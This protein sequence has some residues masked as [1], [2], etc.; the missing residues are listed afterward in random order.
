M[1]RSRCKSVRDH[2]RGGSEGAERAEQSSRRRVWGQRPGQ[3]GEFNLSTLWGFLIMYEDKTLVCKDCGAEFVFT[4]GE[5]EFYAEKGFQNE[6]TRCPAALP[7]VRAR[8]MMPSVLNAESPLRF[9]SSPERIGPFTAASAL[10]PAADNRKSAGKARKSDCSSGLFTCLD[11]M[12][13]KKGAPSSRQSTP[14]ANFSGVGTV[15]IYFRISSMRTLSRKVTREK[16]TPCLW[17]RP[18]RPI[19]CR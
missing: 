1:V 9:P 10:P 6:P 8:C 18:V 3:P 17:A 15:S 11:Q 4:A 12:F 2:P 19:R 5:Q 14:S 13:S 7:A 16:L